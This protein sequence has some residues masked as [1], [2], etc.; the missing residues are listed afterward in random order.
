MLALALCLVPQ[1]PAPAPAPAATAATPTP[2]LTPAN[3]T[4]WRDH[5][6]PQAAEERWRAIA[7]RPTVADGLQD[8]ARQRR[9]MLLWL[10]NGHPLGC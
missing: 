8:A 4:A 7:W 1:A 2:T 6:A 5:L 3:L 9:P 10:M